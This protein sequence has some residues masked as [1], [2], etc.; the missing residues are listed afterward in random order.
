MSP[1][2]FWMVA[3]FCERQHK[4]GRGEVNPAS[5][6]QSWHC[7]RKGFWDSLQPGLCAFWE[8]LPGTGAFSPAYLQVFSR[9]QWSR[10]VLFLQRVG[11][12]T[13][14]CDWTPSLNTL[15]SLLLNTSVFTCW[16]L[17]LPFGVSVILFPVWW[18]KGLFH[19]VV[20]W[21]LAWLGW[22]EETH[23]PLGT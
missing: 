11:S 7:E 5:C 23:C 9:A 6:P 10:P 17:V 18:Y 4:P 14:L 3:P 22:V 13:N 1:V 15:S 16:H 12:V 20:L 8:S 2:P 21:E 19:L